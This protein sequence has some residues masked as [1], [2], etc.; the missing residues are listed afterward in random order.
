MI[1]M[2]SPARLAVRCAAALAALTLSAAAWPPTT[3]RCR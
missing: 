2:K 1:K 3:R